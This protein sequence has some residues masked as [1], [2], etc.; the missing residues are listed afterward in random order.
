MTIHIQVRLAEP[1]WRAVGERELKITLPIGSS[2]DSL[3]NHLVDQYPDLKDE[4]RQTPP[5]VFI[6]DSEADPDTI[7]GDGAHVHLVWPIAGG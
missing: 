4:L 5:Q 1:F 6:A 7:L 3:L 2:I